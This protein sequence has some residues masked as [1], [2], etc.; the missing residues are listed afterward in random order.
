MSEGESECKEQWREWQRGDTITCISSTLR[1]LN[2]KK[3]RESRVEL[4]IG[5]DDGRGGDTRTYVLFVLRLEKPEARSR[6]RA[7][8]RRSP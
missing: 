1:F 8:A 3:T 5:S 2:L 6:A 7:K 4:E